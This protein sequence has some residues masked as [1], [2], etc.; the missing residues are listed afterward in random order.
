VRSAMP[1]RVARTVYG[2]YNLSK[3]FQ[4]AASDD[5]EL[6]AGV[7]VKDIRPAL[8]W[9]LSAR[10]LL[11]LGVL[12]TLVR[13][14]SKSEGGGNWLNDAA[15]SLFYGPFGLWLGAALLVILARPDHRRATARA[16]RR[17]C[18]VALLAFAMAA[19]VVVY[20]SF[21]SGP[22]FSEWVFNEAPFLMP[23]VALMAPLAIWYAIFLLCSTYLM[24][25]NGFAERGHPLLRP[26]TS[27]WLAWVGALLA[28][29]LP[30][31]Q[32]PAQ[33]PGVVIATLLGP[34]LATLISIWEWRA[35]QK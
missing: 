12:V 17:P 1:W 23:V 18:L 5:L 29:V 25:H 21:A 7:T 31:S 3:H 27:T 19:I 28:F 9:A 33:T 35:C 32:E 34:T 13:W 6:V 14:A 22:R 26:I 8:Q 2:P 16:V 20:N 4:L 30:A 15:M 24:H 11:T 10:T